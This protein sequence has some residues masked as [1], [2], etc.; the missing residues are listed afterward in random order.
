MNG[1]MTCGTT[2]EKTAGKTV[3]DTADRAAGATGPY[4]SRAPG[5][6][7]V[8]RR[9]RVSVK[10]ERTVRSG[11]GVTAVGAPLHSPARRTF[12]PARPPALRAAFP[13]APAESRRSSHLSFHPADVRTLV[14]HG[15]LVHLYGR[16]HID[17]Q[18]VAGALCC[19]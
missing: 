6:D 14:T 12:R 11:L 1:G 5:R 15:P 4:G 8:R 2:T 13:A 17:L 10:G 7:C 9:P 16:Q 3:D 19:R 18:R